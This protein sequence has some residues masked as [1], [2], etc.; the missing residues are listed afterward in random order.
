MQP[1]RRA[2]CS[3]NECAK[4][5]GRTWRSFMTLV[6]FYMSTGL[7]HYGDCPLPQVVGYKLMMAVF[8]LV[9]PSNKQSQL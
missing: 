4:G 8:V 5:A 6:W 7:G 2:T 9:G 3:C 1:V